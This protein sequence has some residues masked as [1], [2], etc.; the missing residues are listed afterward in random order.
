MSCGAWPLGIARRR[1][2]AIC[3]GSLM[4]RIGAKLVFVSAGAVIVSTLSKIK[5]LTVRIL[6]LSAHLVQ[7]NVCAKR[8]VSW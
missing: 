4:N 7:P 8:K 5:H 3:N 2:G 6:D 1:M